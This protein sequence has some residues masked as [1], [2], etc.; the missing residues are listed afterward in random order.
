MHELPK[1][2]WD[3][4]ALRVFWSLV[5]VDDDIGGP[6]CHLCHLRQDESCT[7]GLLLPIL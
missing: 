1:P 5:L 3:E 6:A 7:V 2:R 4:A